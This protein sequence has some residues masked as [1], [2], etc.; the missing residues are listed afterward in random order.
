[1]HSVYVHVTSKQGITSCFTFL[2][3]SNFMKLFI[4]IEL[5]RICAVTASCLFNQVNPAE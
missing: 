5:V 4:L 2:V 1:M 3:Q